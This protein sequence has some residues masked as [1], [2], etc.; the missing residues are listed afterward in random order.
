MDSSSGQIWEYV[1]INK[2]K[3]KTAYDQMAKKGI[4]WFDQSVTLNITRGYTQFSSFET[5]YLDNFLDELF[6]QMLRKKLSENSFDN[7]ILLSK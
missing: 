7:M 1:R 6:Y 2:Q 3:I 4:L 5:R